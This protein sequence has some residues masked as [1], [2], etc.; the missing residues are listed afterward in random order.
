MGYLDNLKKFDEFLEKHNIGGI[1]ELLV[2]DEVSSIF[3]IADE[4]VIREYDVESVS[5]K[6]AETICEYIYDW[7]MNTEATAA[8]VARIMRGCLADGKFTIDDIRN[9]D[10]KVRQNIN[11]MI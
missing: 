10:P 9:W 11:W 8:E 6:D 7:V 3:P 5:K 2:A 1:T 4:T